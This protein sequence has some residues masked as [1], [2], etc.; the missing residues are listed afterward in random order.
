MTL[1]ITTGAGELADLASSQD[2]CGPAKPHGA[3][4]KDYWG[5]EEAK[6]TFGVGFPS[7][8]HSYRACYLLALLAF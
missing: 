8:A 2:L 3:S 5:N 4:P 7:E 1:T 6:V